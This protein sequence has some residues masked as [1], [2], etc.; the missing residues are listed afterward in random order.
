MSV[1]SG[2]QVQVGK[3]NTENEK[4]IPVLVYYGSADKVVAALIAGNTQNKPLRLPII[5]VQ[6]SNLSVAK[7]RMHG[8]GV[9][10]RSSFVPVGGLVPDD[11]QV[12]HQRMPNFYD[13]ELKVGICVSNTDQHLQIL[14]QILPLF[15]PQLQLQSSDGLFD[16]TRQTTV[17]LMSGPTFEQNILLPADTR[18]IQ[19]TMTFKMDI[20]LS[21]PA[22]V[23]QDF[24][25]N[26]YLRIG[27]VNA[28]A[29]TDQEIIAELDEEDIPYVLVSSGDI[30]AGTIVPGSGYNNGTYTNVALSGGTGTGVIATVT[31]VNS[32]VATVV[33][34][35]VG[36]GYTVGDVLTALNSYIGG[37]G[38]G[39]SVEVT[40][41]LGF[42]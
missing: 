25:K 41:D 38:S 30:T 10:R 37:A 36:T 28:A 24:I 3:W 23:R 12:V 29:T 27:I 6:I 20:W 16:M 39:F 35:A 32:V 40:S 21:I 2:L 22:E 4:L 42:S 31:V 5:A 18:I 34:T 11:I 26:I 14:E 17:E 19:S 7:D 13:L 8:M 9:Q 15:D 1:F 33:F